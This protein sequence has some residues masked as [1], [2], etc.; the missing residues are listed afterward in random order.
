[1]GRSDWYNTVKHYSFQPSEYTT[2]LKLGIGEEGL[3]GRLR[4]EVP[5]VVRG[6]W[7][8]MKIGMQVVLDPGHI[9][10]WG[11]SSPPKKGGR[12]EIGDLRFCQASYMM[13]FGKRTTSNIE[14]KDPGMPDA[15]M[16]RLHICCTMWANGSFVSAEMRSFSAAECG[17]T[18]IVI[19]GMFR[20]WFSA[21]YPLT[22]FRI[23]QSAF[24][25][26]LMSL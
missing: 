26:I 21:N 3:S 8:K 17:K 11:P 23:P 16:H 5:S 2:V 7:I 10:R 14:G 24:R 9:V 18:I 13:F 15:A 4:T 25:K 6:G 1:M 22:T 20:T 12:A 19:C